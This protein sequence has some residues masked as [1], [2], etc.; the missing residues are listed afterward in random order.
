MRRKIP[1]QRPVSYTHLDV[2]KRQDYMNPAQLNFFRQR[3]TVMKR[4]LM[5]NA[6]VTGAHLRATEVAADP[7]DREMCIRDRVP[8]ARP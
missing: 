4:E 8:T 6:E 3:L 7:V 5:E 1:T 2:Y